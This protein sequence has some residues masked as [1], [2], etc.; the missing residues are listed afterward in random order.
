MNANQFAKIQVVHIRAA[1]NS[2]KIEGGVTE[3]E[4]LVE[5]AAALVEEI[6]STEVDPHWDT[7]LKTALDVLTQYGVHLGETR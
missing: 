7:L 6:R 4:A 3:T 1:A 2:V 5:A